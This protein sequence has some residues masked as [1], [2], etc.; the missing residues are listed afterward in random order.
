MLKLSMTAVQFCPSI[1]HHPY[2][3]EIFIISISNSTMHKIIKYC[4]KLNL[5]EKER[6]R[7]KKR[8]QNEYYHLL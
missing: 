7:I 3:N 2:A 5:I 8:Q 4:F 1:D 6:K